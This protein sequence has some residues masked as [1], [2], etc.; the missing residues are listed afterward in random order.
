MG[1]SAG[2][3]AAA[4]HLAAA[5]ATADRT[6]VWPEWLAPA[7]PVGQADRR[8]DRAHFARLGGTVLLPELQADPVQHPGRL[9]EQAGRLGGD[10]L[11]DRGFGQPAGADPGG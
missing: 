9:P 2:S 8:A 3:D 4:K 1:R 5:A 11:A 7:G 6:P 10:E